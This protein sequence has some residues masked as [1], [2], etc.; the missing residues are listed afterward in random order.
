[1][2]TLSEAELERLQRALV[3]LL[4]PLAYDSVDSWRLAASRSVQALLGADKA[5]FLLP[6]DGHQLLVGE[7]LDTAGFQA[8]AEYYWQLDVGF[9]RRRK[10]LG[11]EVNSLEMVYDMGTLG[12]TEIYNDFSR[13]YQFLDALAMSTDLDPSSFPAT[14]VVYH[15]RESTPVFGERGVAILN[16]LLPA[17]KV[18][19]STCVRFAAQ[20]ADLLRFVDSLSEGCMVFDASGALLHESP[21]VQLVI[22]EDTHAALI[23]N[24]MRQAA[25]H[26]IGC[27]P[28]TTGLASERAR[29]GL[30]ATD[31]RVSRTGHA[32][33]RINGSLLSGAVVDREL[34]V[35][36]TV[37]RLHT[38]PASDA[39]LRSTFG[40]TRREIEV[41]RMLERGLTSAEIARELGITVHTAER[42][43]EHVMGKLGVRTRSAIGAKVR[44]V[45]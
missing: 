38:Q 31:S 32:H 25:S 36:I 22:G 16:L 21:A 3:T 7:A 20:R 13:R 45:L 2:L 42:H 4:S 34:L 24:A 23:R 37:E 35:L 33:Y 43:T 27:L 5:G 12:Q 44:D 39:A 19:A 26:L 17:L 15:D 9:Q 40:L 29:L 10:E 1:M 41:T 11:L 28:R 14:V 18:G 30:R 8:Y 6:L